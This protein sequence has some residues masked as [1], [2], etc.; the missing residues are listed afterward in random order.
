MSLSDPAVVALLVFGVAILYSSVG[1]GGASGY[2]AVLAL[3]GYSAAAISTT[4]LILNVGVSGIAFMAYRSVAPPRRMVLIPLLAGSLPMAFIGGRTHVSERLFTVV[5]C[6]ALAA[7]AMRLL[8]SP[9]GIGQVGNPNPVWL[10]GIGAAIGFVSGM[11]GVGGGIFLSPILLLARWAT[12]KET[13]A[14][15]ALFILLNSLSGLLARGPEIGPA[16]EAAGPFL[17]VAM[18]GGVL[19]SYLASRRLPLAALR[20]ALGVVLLVAAFK[21][22]TKA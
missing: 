13:A 10:L 3:A 1:H 11:I 2:L 14:I 20:S 9:K 21:L 6:L 8:F 4:A 16:L 19:G 15:S 17:V 12:L 22:A 5:L 18:G 7:A